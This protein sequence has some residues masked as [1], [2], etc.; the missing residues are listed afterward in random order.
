MSDVGL[1]LK[2]ERAVWENSRGRRNDRIRTDNSSLH[3]AIGKFYKRLDAAKRKL[4]KTFPMGTSRRAKELFRAEQFLLIESL[5]SQLGQASLYAEDGRCKINQYHNHKLELA[6]AFTQCLQH[7]ERISLTQFE[8]VQHRIN[9]FTSTISSYLHG[10]ISSEVGSRVGRFSWQRQ[11]EMASTVG[12]SQLA[13]IHYPKD[14]T[15][16]SYMRNLQLIQ[17]MCMAIGS[18]PLSDEQHLKICEAGSFIGPIFIELRSWAVLEEVPLLL[19]QC[20]RT[21]SCILGTS[22]AA[23]RYGEHSPSGWSWGKVMDEMLAKNLT[24]WCRLLLS[25]RGG[26]GSVSD[27]YAHALKQICSSSSTSVADLLDCCS[28]VARALLIDKQRAISVYPGQNFTEAEDRG[29]KGN[30]L[31]ELIS[32]ALSL[33]LL[34]SMQNTA[35]LSGTNALSPGDVSFITAI[36]R[37]L[38]CSFRLVTA[39]TCTGI[40]FEDAAQVLLQGRDFVEDARVASLPSTVVWLEAVCSASMLCLSIDAS[41]V[42]VVA[43]SL[44][45]SDLSYE[46]FERFSGLSDWIWVLGSCKEAV[47]RSMWIY[48]DVASVQWLGLLTLRSLLRPPYMRPVEVDS[49][50]VRHTDEE[51]SYSFKT[52][53]TKYRNRKTG[54]GAKSLSP[55]FDDDHT[56]SYAESVENEHR[57]DLSAVTGS[58]DNHTVEQS[59][60]SEV[61]NFTTE[62]TMEKGV[63]LITV[64]NECLMRHVQSDEV[65]EQCLLAVHQLCITTYSGKLRIMNTGINDVLF[66]M[67][68]QRSAMSAYLTGLCEVCL[69]VFNED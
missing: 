36:E 9:G 5:S 61:V 14:I 7:M 48:K 33:S 54:G 19:V 18:S 43:S 60:L 39:S 23:D 57:D 44:E 28:S 49:L 17:I 37:E 55:S 21:L 42:E 50:L 27:T 69:D 4:A 64:I 38:S 53:P 52:S 12:S 11:L 22:A 40:L 47:I 56:A 67:C 45:R 34:V 63:A 32:N 31:E 68:R 26:E 46:L 15:F 3:T 6:G 25:Y 58:D 16:L 65:L 59:I 41:G 66:R 62:Q 8:K 1:F 13:N 35:I 51:E 2:Y 24:F 30:I 29:G 20:L 10:R